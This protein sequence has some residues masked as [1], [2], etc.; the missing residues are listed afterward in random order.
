MKTRNS[1][2][3]KKKK[4][5]KQI[6]SVTLDPDVVASVFEYESN[7]SKFVGEAI[8]MKIKQIKKGETKWKQ[9]VEW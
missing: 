7:F 3:Y 9:Y 6:Y 5:R 8:E 1:E 4:Q 2:Q